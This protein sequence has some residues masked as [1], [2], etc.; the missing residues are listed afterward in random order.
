MLTN[1]GTSA[2]HSSSVGRRSGNS[3][4]SYGIGNVL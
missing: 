3:E 4:I 2:L 1:A